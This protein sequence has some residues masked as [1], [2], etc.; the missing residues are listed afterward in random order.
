VRCVRC[1]PRG[2]PSQAQPS[3]LRPALQAPRCAALRVV[4]RVPDKPGVCETLCVLCGLIVRQARAPLTSV[5]TFGGGRAAHR[6]ASLVVVVLPLSYIRVRLGWA[7]KRKWL[8]R[9]VWTPRVHGELES[10]SAGQVGGGRAAHRPGRATSWWWCCG[11][12]PASARE[13]LGTGPPPS[14]L[15]VPCGAEKFGE[16][17]VL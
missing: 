10:D 16:R 15:P 2:A 3:A 7:R 6:R 9:A 17:G 8:Q 14:P 5:A 4:V 12:T 1:L 11:P 13:R